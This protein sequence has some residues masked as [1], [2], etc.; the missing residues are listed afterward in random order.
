MAVLLINASADFV[1][2]LS[3]FCVLYYQNVMSRYALPRMAATSSRYQSTYNSSY[4][5]HPTSYSSSGYVR[6]KVDSSSRSRTSDHAGVHRRFESPIRQD[7]TGSSSSGSSRPIIGSRPLP[8]GPS[9]RLS[10]SSTPSKYTSSIA[11]RAAAFE[12]R[13]RPQPLRAERSEAFN[14]S[15][16]NYGTL[17]GTSKVTATPRASPTLDSSASVRSTARSGLST[18]SE[19]RKSVRPRSSSVGAGSR[20][21]TSTVVSTPKDLHT[22]SAREKRQVENGKEDKLPGISSASGNADGGSNSKSDSS[23]SSSSNGYILGGTASD[24]YQHRSSGQALTAISESER[25]SQLR[26]GSTNEFLV[27]FCGIFNSF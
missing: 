16:R 10:A 14:R 1:S 4:T 7:S 11:S 25:T 3:K 2:L 8:T 20:Y 5:S 22:S 27:Y 18:D 13:V 24:D 26:R 23:H 6:T 21:L 17:S 12:A 9:S 15:E 19:E